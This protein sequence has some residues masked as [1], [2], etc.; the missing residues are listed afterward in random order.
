MQFYKEHYDVIVIGGGLAG[1][2]SALVLR[3]QGKD[4]LVLERHNLPGGPATSFVRGGIE[5]EAAL[6]EMMGIGPK[7]HRLTIGKFLEEHGVCVDWLRLPEAYHASLPG[8]ERTLHPGFETFA[9]EIDSEAPGTYETVLRVLNLCRAVFDSINALSDGP[10]SIPKMLREHEALVKTVGYSTEEVLAT[11]NLPQKAL[12]LLAPYWMYV[13]MPLSE[14]PFTVY[15]LVMADYIGYGA[16]IPRRFSYEISVKLAERV[17][18]L[19]VQIEYR[20][21]VEKILVRNRHVYGVRTARGDEIHSDF[22]ISAPYPNKVYT[23]MIEPL[24]AVPHRAIRSVN[25][26]R[27]SLSAFSV[28]LVLDQSAD[29]LNIRD[30]NNFHGDTMDTDALYEN[31]AGLGPYRY[32]TSI[33]LNRGNPGATPPG[34]CVLSITTLPRIEAWRTVTADDYDRVKHAIARQMIDEMSRY[35][36]VNL[37]DH[38]L[39]LVIETPMTVAH[40]TG[41]WNGCIYGYSHTMEDHIVARLL[42]ADE[43]KFFE[44][45]VFAGAHQLAGDGMGPAI[46]NG[47]RAAQEVLDDCKRKEAAK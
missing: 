17:E 29:A 39:E 2:T 19:G 13:G 38:V 24:S 46:T 6:H 9:H 32:L 8:I 4:V 31:L 33:C 23:S 42:T 44:G 45:L 22:V 28:I 26:K 30:Y 16:Y 35:Y 20:Q 5:L 34:T 41:M 36:G 15:S 43:E 1:L 18:S 40:Y 12:D 10:E 7:E 47:R 37:L 14:L 25:G 3:E 21:H 27:L 11:F